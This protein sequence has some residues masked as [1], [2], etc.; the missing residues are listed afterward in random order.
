MSKDWQAVADAMNTQMEQLAMTQT[1]LANRSRVS[2]ALLRQIKNAVP[3]R[4]SPR[5]LAAISEAL[6][7]PSNHLERVAG[8]ETPSSVD[9]DRIGRLEAEVSDLRERVAELARTVSSIS[10]TPPAE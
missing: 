3:G 2:S 10:T 1:E 5:T 7:W 4:R 9:G 6:G 8:G